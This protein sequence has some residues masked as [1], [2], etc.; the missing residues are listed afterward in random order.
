[1]ILLLSS[2]IT[3]FAKDS[4]RN[5][6]FGLTAN[7]AN[8]VNVNTGD[9][10]TVV[11]TLDQTAGDDTTMYGMQAEIE[12]DTEFFEL[13]EDSLVKENGIESS[14]LGMRDNKSRLYLNYLPLSGGKEWPKEMK[15]GTFQL[16]VIGQTGTSTLTNE[17]YLVTTSDGKGQYNADAGDLT[18]VISTDCTVR[19]MPNGGTAVPD[20][21][22]IYGEQIKEPQQPTRDGYQLSGWY[23]DLDLSK[24]WNF[25]KDKVSGNMTLYAGWEKPVKKHVKPK[26]N[27]IIWIPISIVLAAGLLFLLI[28]KIRRR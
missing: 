6:H 20:Q 1:M 10:I 17:N 27:W 3:V 13:V 16:K 23:Q 24:K 26:S 28:K 2:P 25:K 7:G 11:L 8:T 15:V 19:F 5:Y 14:V 18:V 12:Y 9:T 21:T 4:D 22:V